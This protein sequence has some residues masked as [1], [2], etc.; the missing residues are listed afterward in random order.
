MQGPS[1]ISVPLGGAKG[2]AL[3]ICLLPR[4]FTSGPYPLI[5]RT[6]DTD[7]DAG[8]APVQL[9][10]NSEFLYEWV[11][12]PS[13]VEQVLTD[14]AEIF[15][16]D[17]SSG[18][19]GR[20]RPAGAVGTLNV[21]VR[22]GSSV[23]G[24]LALEVRSRKLDYLREYRWMLRDI[25]TQVT[26]IVMDRFAASET[27]FTQ[28]ETR[29]AVTLYQRFAFL[30][31]LFAS[32]AFQG[33][34]A[35]IARRP[36]V[37]WIENS[38][39]VRP[40]APLRGSPAL[41]R[42]L[43][44]PG[45]RQVWRGGPL[46]S[47]PREL[48]RRRTESTLDTTPN[49]FVRFALERWQSVMLEIERALAVTGD[50][51]AVRRG[52]REIAQTVEQIESVLQRSTFQGLS[53]LAR[54]PSD[55]QVL[56]RRQGYREVFR[57]YLEFE[58]AARLSWRLPHSAFSAGQHDVATLYEMWAFIQLASITANLVGKQ[59]D[60]SPLVERRKDG[61]NVVLQQGKE[62]VVSGTVE[63]AGQ[64]LG[65]D[66]CFNRT[67]ARGTGSWT[68]PMRPDFSLVIRSETSAAL[69]FEPVVLH[70]DAK[71]R[72]SALKEL[73][74]N[75]DE[76]ANL[77]DASASAG[78]K[79]GAVRSDLL[80]MHA[81]RDAVR[82]SAGAYVLF[83]GT[84]AEKDRFMEYNELLPGLG[85]FVLRPSEEGNPAG[86]Q[87]LREFLDEVLNHVTKRLTQHE[88]GRFWRKEVYDLPG[89]NQTAHSSE[90]HQPG[91]DTTVL[92]GHVKSQAHWDWIA[93]TRAYNVRAE[94]RA[95]GVRQNADLLRSHFLLLYCPSTG[96]IGLTRIVSDPELVSQESMVEAKYP[97]PKGSYICVQW[98]WPSLA[99]STIQFTAQHIE[100]YLTSRGVLAGA[101]TMV[102]W[103]D[104]ANL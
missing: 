62:S 88:R 48:S 65:L 25:A 79:G 18:I 95:G 99:Q 21:V 8:V 72:I 37:L 81:Y 46:G 16:P 30:R 15:Q 77:D 70:F 36:H 84:H 10:E 49:R 93:R 86:A 53:P 2:A 35:E 78:S 40:G 87:A 11:G 32:E 96:Q 51:P 91:P 69:A 26:E 61:L 33:A 82:R 7:L 1:E 89:P 13:G 67:F 3:R 20:L 92:L 54:F 42:Q 104:L 39:S 94:G 101:P 45:A 74:G 41:V 31:S 5:D 52:R 80:K 19:K 12:L 23:L 34:L 58:L 100:Q 43:T 9:L 71:Y 14:P 102:R 90:V 22:S 60:I 47:I 64:R 56:Q 17:T 44:G 29:D 38:E 68:R 73:F 6:G 27:T 57:A 59:F 55:D 66:L 50:T 24:E 28:D 75:E 98:R 4:P 83:P 103:F 85:A 76:L 63:R 97:D